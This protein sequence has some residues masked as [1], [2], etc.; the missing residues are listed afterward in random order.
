MEQMFAFFFYLQCPLGGREGFAP[1][2]QT[3][4]APGDGRRSCDEA[5]ETLMYG[6]VFQMY[7]FSSFDSAEMLLASLQKGRENISKFWTNLH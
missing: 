1:C 6:R 5:L 2:C 4:S 3:V 7:Y